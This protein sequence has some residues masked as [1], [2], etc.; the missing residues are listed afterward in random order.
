[1]GFSSILGEDSCSTVRHSQL[2]E[3]SEQLYSGL[4]SHLSQHGF[5]LSAALVL[6]CVHRFYWLGVCGYLTLALL[7]TVQAHS[8]PPVNLRFAKSILSLA[9]PGPS[10]WDSVE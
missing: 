10:S 7:S 5:P 9:G 6:L 4:F 3:P 8:Q 2:V 1:M